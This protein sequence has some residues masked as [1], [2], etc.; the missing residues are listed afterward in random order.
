M[1]TNS[2]ITGPARSGRKAGL[3]HRRL[4]VPAESGRGPACPVIQLWAVPNETDCLV[5]LQQGQVD[6]IS[7]DNAILQGLA[8]QD[9]NTMIVGPAFTTEPY[10]M[11]ISKAHPEFTSFVNGVL[12]QERADGTWAADLHQM[13]R[14][15]HPRHRPAAQATTASREPAGAR[16]HRRAHRQNWVPPSGPAR[17]PA[18]ARYR[19]HPSDARCSSALPVTTADGVGD[20]R[21]SM[22]DL[23]RGQLA[24]LVVL[25]AIS[26]ER[27]NRS[28][29]S[30]GG[31]R[32]THRSLS[33]ANRCRCPGAPSDDRSRA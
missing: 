2:T 33:R 30:T 1:P 3:R 4:D 31:S 23:W 22:A 16:R 8:A 14:A 24:L 17:A 27:G 21:A 11:A 18:R 29:V 5:M 9:P 28:S 19:R 10:G 32:P 25:E 6:A 26:E 20:A 12:A 7:T 15:L 13:A